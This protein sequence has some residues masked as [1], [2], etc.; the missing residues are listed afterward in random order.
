MAAAVAMSSIRARMLPT[1]ARVGCWQRG[2]I[3]C[4][5]ISTPFFIATFY[6]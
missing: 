3:A 2:A 6:K 5:K 4:A 1:R